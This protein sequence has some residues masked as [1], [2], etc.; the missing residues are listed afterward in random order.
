MY[1]IATTPIYRQFDAMWELEWALGEDAKIKKTGFPGVIFVTVDMDRESAI[2][3]IKEY[4]TTAI[5]KVIP[6][7]IM[8]HTDKEKIISAAMELAS[9]HI[10]KD[11]SFAVRCKR[12][13]TNL[14]SSKEL[15][16][17]LGAAVVDKIGATVNLEYPQKTLKIEVIKR[18]TGISVLTP[19]EIITKDVAE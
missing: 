16:G 2:N 11:D 12:R 18:R 5:Y 1:F 4:E 9:K 3:T 19:D 7:D 10:S 6:I 8:V 17:E 13:G 15:E 14:F